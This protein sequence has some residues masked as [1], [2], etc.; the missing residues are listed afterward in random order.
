MDLSSYF[1]PLTKYWW[2]L[3]IATLVAII[4]SSIVALRQLPVYQTHATLLIGRSVYEPN[5][6]AN[7]LYLGQQLAGFYADIGNRDNIRAATQDA[8]GLNSLP[9]YNVRTLPNSQ[10]LEIDVTDTNPRRAMAVANE[11]A[12]QLIKLTPTNQSGGQQSH[13]DFI[14]QQLNQLEAGIK[15]TNDEIAKKQAELTNL[16]SASQIADLQQQ[17]TALNTKL[18]NLQTNYATL[19]NNS[20]PGALNTLTLIESASLPQAPIGP[21]KPM[22]ILLSAAIAL[23]IAAGAAYLLEF[24]DNTLQNPEEVTRITGSET[25]GFLSDIGNEDFK[26]IY[27]AKNPRSALAEAYRSLRTNLEFLGVNKPLK[28]ILVTSSGIGEGK[29]TVSANLATVLAQGGKRVAIIDADMRRPRLHKLFGFEN[30]RGLSDIFLGKADIQDAITICGDEKIMVIP[31]GNTPPNPTDLINSGRM[32]TILDI[33]KESVDIVIVDGPPFLV[34]DAALLSSK[35][36]GVL[37]IVRY[38][39]SLK[40]AVKEVVDQLNFLEARVLGVVINSLPKSF[41]EYGQHYRYYDA[42]YRDD[43]DGEK[44]ASPR[45]RGWSA[46]NIRSLLSKNNRSA[47]ALA[48][49]PPQIKDSA[50][51]TP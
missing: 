30:S 11:L 3:G 1:R 47:N 9:P 43:D 13:Q 27:V 18:S 42:V 4:S 38:G 21:N 39:H 25:I 28:S 29:T 20:Q 7:D 6:S 19:I 49:K 14:D 35:V 24:L 51:K 33:L 50:R 40:A 5:P 45:R 34:A 2:L 15:E 22:I 17:I 12:N 26:G 44:P 41:D 37:L 23:A 10:M 32:D 46:L 31:G 36:D 48:K 16:N 8:L